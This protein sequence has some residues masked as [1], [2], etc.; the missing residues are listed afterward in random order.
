MCPHRFNS[1]DV[2][3]AVGQ[4]RF[5]PVIFHSWEP[6]VC[7]H[8]SPTGRLRW[9]EGGGEGERVS[10]WVC[11]TFTDIPSN[12]WYQFSIITHTHIQMSQLFLSLPLTDIWLWLTGIRRNYFLSL[13]FGTLL[14]RNSRETK[15]KSCN[16]NNC[17][18]VS[19]L[20]VVLHVLS[21]KDMCDY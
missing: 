5:L 10:Q 14:F 17:H 4:S 2:L 8:L 19:A 7:G 1:G 16:V 11:F 6:A 12:M 9:R 13:S 21:S 18:D 15:E 20:P 3:S